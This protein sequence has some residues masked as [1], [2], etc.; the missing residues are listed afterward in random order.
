MNYWISSQ[1]ACS[2]G[3]YTY[4]C[5]RRDMRTDAHAQLFARRQGGLHSTY[6]LKQ[7]LMGRKVVRR[8]F[9]QKKVG[10]LKIEQ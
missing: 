5:N 2:L 7:H 1:G 8:T 9:L 10:R 4:K 3:T 6:N